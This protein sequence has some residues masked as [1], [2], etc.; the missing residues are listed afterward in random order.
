M[1]PTRRIALLAAG[2][3][4][5]AA[6]QGGGTGGGGDGAGASPGTDGSPAAAGGDGGGDGG[7][8]LARIQAAG[9]IKVSTDPAYPPQSFLNEETNELEGFDIDVATEIAER[10]GVDVQFETPDF[11]AV[12]AGGWSNRWDM[13]VGSITITPEREEILDFTQPYYFVP[14]QMATTEGTGIETLEDFA[15]TTICVGESTTYQFWLEGTLQL[16]EEAGEPLPPPEDATVST[17]PTDINC[18]EAWRDGRMDS[19]GWVSSVTTV[20]QAVADGMP[21]IPVGDFVFNE[22]LGV[23]F[24][25]SVEDNDS[26]V[27]AVD[28]II[29]E[30]HE[31]GTLAE[32]SEQWFEGIDY[33]QPQ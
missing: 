31:D 9:V 27:Q 7:D 19:Q 32:L 12:V 15:G 13:S 6:C 29:A 1:T 10:L 18:A 20:E 28:E 30:M 4:L 26:L 8:Y 23:A 33:S 3:L 17:L 25:R 5:L 16:P 11:S 21:V 22:G 24:D 14:V 2:L